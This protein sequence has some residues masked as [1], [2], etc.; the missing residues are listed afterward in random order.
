MKK[1]LILAAITAALAT[2]LAV[3]AEA[4]M[5]GKLRVA[6]Q[7]ASSNIEAGKSWG[8]ANHSSRLGVKGSE[9]LGGGIRAIYKLEF[10]VNPTVEG[11]NGG[12]TQR[13]SYVGLDGAFGTF[14]MGVHDTPL[15]VSTMKLD[16]FEDTAA[17]FDVGFG[18]PAT[19]DTATGAITSSHSG[20]GLFDSRRV[21]GV[22]AYVSPSFAGLTLMG[23]LVQTPA[24]D[25]FEPDNGDAA[26]P[27]GAYSLAAMYSNGPWYG[28]LAFESISSESLLGDNVSDYNKWR[29]GL[30]IR[31]FQNLSASFIYEAREAKGS[32]S[33]WETQSWQLQAGYEYL[34]G[35]HVK[36]MYGEYLGDLSNAFAGGGVG[37]SNRNFNTWALGLQYDLSKRTD[38]QVLYRVKDVDSIGGAGADTANGIDEDIYA[39]QLDHSF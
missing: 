2:P 8:M 32:G 15:K 31:K 12:W 24:G 11:N 6:T 20:V 5:Y 33:N 25:S 26:D 37:L 4:I 3:Q 10:G 23:A 28:S 29:I 35:M 18:A 34:P 27:A 13:N 7:N 19:Y 9:D 22:I 38:I 21:D 1:K 14:L 36:A 16:L 30:G 17:D 39:I